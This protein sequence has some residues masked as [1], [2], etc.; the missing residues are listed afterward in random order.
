MTT[1]PFTPK[2]NAHL[3]PGQ[4]W[5]IPLSDG[6][7]ACG[8][9]LGVERDLEYGSRTVFLGALLD[10]VGPAPPTSESIAGSKALDIG[11][12]HAL[13]IGESGGEILGERP[14]GLDGLVAPDDV[15]SH[16]GRRYAALRAEHLFVAGNPLPTHERRRVSSPL[17]DE[18]LA[19]SATGRGIVQFSS[20]LTDNDFSRLGE[21]LRHYPEMTLRAFGSYDGSIRDLEFLRFFPFL[22]RFDVD[23]VH[24]HLASL[25]GLR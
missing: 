14:L 1:Y 18:M 3:I 25:E 7:F 16:W 13:S 20:M 22:R 5:S 10:W 6:R 15:R 9:V 12:M 24:H 2:S 23:A 8:R 21:W 19:P 11:S 4:F 17:S